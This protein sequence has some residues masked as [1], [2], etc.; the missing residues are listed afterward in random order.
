MSCNDA[1]FFLF[2]FNGLIIII[3]LNTQ[4]FPRI[5]INLNFLHFKVWVDD[6]DVAKQGAD[7]GEGL[8]ILAAPVV[9]HHE[10]GVTV[11]SYWT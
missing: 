10:G 2:Y 3:Y 4:N 8:S 7:S 1:S 5:L 6:V 11:V 9:A